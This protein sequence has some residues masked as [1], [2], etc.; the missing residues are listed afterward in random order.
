MS[1]FV[2]FYD[3]STTPFRFVYATKQVISYSATLYH[4]DTGSFTIVFPLDSELL[5]AVK[6]NDIL[7]YDRDWLMIESISY[8]DT[9]ITMSGCDLN[10]ILRLRL[11]QPGGVGFNYATFADSN[12]NTSATISGMSGIDDYMAVE[13]TSEQCIKFYLDQNIISPDDSERVVPMVFRYSVGGSTVPAFYMARLEVLSDVVKKLCAVK[14][15]YFGYR[16]T[17]DIAN[18][19]LIFDLHTYRD[20]SRQVILSPDWRNIISYSYEH[21]IRDYSN[22]LEVESS[23]GVIIT[24]TETSTIPAGVQRREAYANVSVASSDGQYNTYVSELFADKRESKSFEFTVSAAEYGQRYTLGDFISY[25]DPATREIESA[26]ITA[27][28]KSESNGEVSV[29]ITL[30][31]PRK[32]LLTRLRDRI[33][34]DII[35]R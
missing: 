27:V 34:T 1:E 3:I 2:K 29:K 7:S 26:Q 30:G 18:N 11:T 6:I 20:L 13:G 23:D 15:V 4:A 35:R 14:S 21:G 31:N 33:T 12:I 10:G 19:T 22:V 16:I 32:K 25:R 28:D 5:N 8:N 9:V 24:N 17:A